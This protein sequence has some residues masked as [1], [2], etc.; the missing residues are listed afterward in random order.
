MKLRLAFLAVL[1]TAAAIPAAATTHSTDYTDLW[2][3]PAESGWGV[4][5]V[6]QYDVVFATFFIYG[7]DN[8]P[9]WYVA[10]DTRSVASPAGENTFSGPLFTTIGTYFG[11]PWGGPTQNRQVGNVAFAF[12]SPSNGAVSYTID[13]VPVTKTITRQTWKGNVLTG[14]YIGGL[15]ANGTGCRNGVNNG[16]ILINGELSIG[17]GNFTSPT[18]SIDF[19]TAGGAPGSCTFTG[20][21]GQEGKMGRLDNGTFNCTIQGASSPP[22]GTFV[23]TQVEA[24]TNGV[25]S[26]FVGRDQNCNYDGYFGGTKDV[27]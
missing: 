25:T 3:L 20:T 21:Y 15:T 9:R 5:I 8:T 23:L 1:A 19:F 12:T 2:Y 11:S 14:N 26:R 27:L 10:P 18:F 6:Q 7:P 24:N 16:P 22:F 4:N 13:N 17:H